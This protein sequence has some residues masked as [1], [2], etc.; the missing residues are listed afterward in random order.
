MIQMD[1]NSSR[2]AI[3]SA[4]YGVLDANAEVKSVL[5]DRIAFRDISAFSTFPFV[6]IGQALDRAQSQPPDE[7]HL[8][9]VNIWLRPGEERAARKL[10]RIVKRALDDAKI[11]VPGA[12]VLTFRHE[13]SSLR[14]APELD[15]LHA[16]VRYRLILRADETEAAKRSKRIARP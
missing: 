11:E 10:V 16:T 14:P 2:D 15:A 9:T 7:H 13:R 3:K 6:A 5:Q 4:V 1:R 12:S 8:V